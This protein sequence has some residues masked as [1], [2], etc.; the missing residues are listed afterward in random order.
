VTKLSFGDGNHNIK[1]TRISQF[2][3]TRVQM[4]F[5]PCYCYL[6]AGTEVFYFSHQCGATGDLPCSCPLFAMAVRRGR[7]KKGAHT[8]KIMGFP[9]WKIS[10][11]GDRLRISMSLYKFSKQKLKYQKVTKWK[12]RV[13]SGCRVEG[14]TRCLR[15]I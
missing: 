1:S 2:N 15:H 3:E 14:M 8:K 5:S 11:S 7:N 6:G 13:T 9:T 12:E 10:M 4:L